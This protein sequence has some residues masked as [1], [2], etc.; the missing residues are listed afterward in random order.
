MNRC[1]FVCAGV[2]AAAAA[3]GSYLYTR[4][5]STPPAVAAAAPA[6][7]DPLAALL[8]MSLPDLD[9]NAQALSQW[10][11]QLMVINFWATWCAPCVK[12]MPEL[13]E[14]QKKTPNVRFVGIGVDTAD[15][16]RKFVEKIPVSYPLLVMGA[17]AVDV[18]RGLGNPAGGLPFT[19]VL[20]ANGSIRQK[21][22]DQIDPAAL[23]KSILSL[24]A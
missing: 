23:E 3:A 14:L 15:N 4:S 21:M 2:A 9:G 18:L 1:I 22:L 24:P 12:E 5:R 6:A 10:R 11:G 19:L 7:P 16:M 13:D 20:N 17:G 8:A